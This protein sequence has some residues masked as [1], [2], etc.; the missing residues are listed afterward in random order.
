MTISIIGSGAA[1]ITSATLLSADESN[2]VYLFTS[3]KSKFNLDEGFD[4]DITQ[5]CFGVKYTKDKE[6]F[7][8]SNV[9]L[10]DHSETSILSKSDIILFCLPVHAIQDIATKFTPAILEYPNKSKFV[11]SIYGQGNFNLLVPKALYDAKNINLFAFAFIPWITKM[12]PERTTSTFINGVENFNLIYLQYLENKTIASLSCQLLSNLSIEKVDYEFTQYATEVA[13]ASDNMLLH[14]P[15]L[16]SCF[17]KLYEESEIP[18]FYRDYGQAEQTLFNLVEDELNN[19]KQHIKRLERHLD[20]K[21]LISMSEFEKLANSSEFTI[22]AYVKKNHTT[23][24][25]IPVCKA[26]PIHYKLDTSCRYFKD[27]FTH[28]LHYVQHLARFYGVSVP[29]I[30]EIL[31]WYHINI[32]PLPTKPYFTD[33]PY[34]FN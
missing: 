20:L 11:G 5:S 6:I 34:L 19:L 24:A 14:P 17:D 8:S 26:D 7:L 23:S 16:I 1:G 2:D 13:L 3:D 15:R 21:F 32:K 25:R 30:D 33:R 27:D 9:T 12:R 4:Q 28:G 18:S 29:T 10:A 31:R 22:D